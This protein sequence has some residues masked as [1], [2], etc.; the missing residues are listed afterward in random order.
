[1]ASGSERRRGGWYYGWTIVAI[2]VL[3]QIVANGLP[4][5]ALSLF[6]HPWSQ[7]LHAPISA[8]LLALL[9]M[10][11]VASLASPWV[12]ALADSK[13]ARLL[14]GIGVAGMAVIFV[15]MS[16]ISAIW[17]LLALYAIA[18]PLMV[19]LS[20]AVVCN[21]LVSRWFVKRAGL[22]LGLSAFG[23]GIAGIVLPP[24]VAQLLPVIGWRNIWRA[25]GLIAGLV[26]LPI[27]LLA[28]RDRPTERE[29][30]DYVTGG[31]GAPAVAHAHGGGGA[32]GGLSSLDVLKRKNFLLVAASFITLGCVFVGGMQNIVPI[33]L[34]RG[35]D[36]LTAGLLIS[37]LS[38]AYV[39]STLLMG[40]MSDRFGARPPLLLLS[41]CGAAAALL[42][43]FGT[44]LP[45]LVA[46]TILA[47]A[48]GGMYPVL[49]A[50]LGVEFGPAGVGR[51]YGILSMLTLVSAG[52]PA[53]I[54]RTQELTGSYGPAMLTF[55]AFALIGGGLV[56]QL[57]QR[58]GGQATPPEKDAA[59]QAAGPIL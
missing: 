1:M 13:P 46:G 51:A 43:G 26:V 11:V 14:L 47:G 52:A 41:L 27:V 38:A 9:V 55:A 24:L 56:S 59:L 36:Q 33:A 17:Q 3:T 31:D 21:P 45:A 18:M 8:I 32:A 2:T 25:A 29:G 19:S 23:I 53:A 50:A 40:A 57:R 22:A 16:W 42:I 20:T 30:L 15:A 12:G 10:I 39:V 7:E 35:V 54:A 58:R 48:C 49:A 6:L 4:A 34:S 37:A 5:N 28:V 44:S